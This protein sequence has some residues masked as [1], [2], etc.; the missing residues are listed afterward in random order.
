MLNN[1]KN[2]EIKIKFSYSLFLSEVDRF[3]D[4]ILAVEF[5]RRFSMRL[6]ISSASAFALK[7]ASKAMFLTRLVTTAKKQSLRREL[8]ALVHNSQLENSQIT[9]ELSKAR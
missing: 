9:R 4:I 7:N 6:R 8:E 3:F 1:A 5:H 2:V